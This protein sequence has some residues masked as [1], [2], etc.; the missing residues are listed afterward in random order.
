[1]DF[2]W[3]ETFAGEQP[4][5]AGAELTPW[6]VQISFLVHSG[7]QKGWKS[8][9]WGCPAKTSG[10]SSCKGYFLYHQ[11]FNLAKTISLWSAEITES[12]SDTGEER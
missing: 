6:A 2:R 3:V 8:T 1:M 10:V 5:R 11:G 7:E 4:G 9:L 12:L